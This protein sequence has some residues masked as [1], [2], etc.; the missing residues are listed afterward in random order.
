M[1]KSFYAPCWNISSAFNVVFSFPCSLLVNISASIRRVRLQMD[2]PQSSVSQS[3]VSQGQGVQKV[4]LDLCVHL[5]PMSV[6]LMMSLGL[7]RF[8]I[9]CNFSVRHRSHVFDPTLY[10]LHCFMISHFMFAVWLMLLSQRY[11]DRVVSALQLWCLKLF[12]WLLNLSLKL[13]S[14]LPIYMALLPSGWETVAL[15]TTASVQHLP[16]IGH[17]SF[18]WQLHLSFGVFLFGPDSILVL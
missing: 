8:L 5:L 13:G 2:V 6:R 12:L 11:F 1:Q 16:G 18:F 15:Y 17:F 9:M 14:V 3:S 10:V 4:C 7:C